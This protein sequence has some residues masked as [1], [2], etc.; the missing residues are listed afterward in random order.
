MRSYELLG[1]HELGTTSNQADKLV[2]A[3]R[4]G[5]DLIKKYFGH[6]SGLIY[7]QGEI[8][9]ID[10][11]LIDWYT[12]NHNFDANVTQYQ[13]KSKRLSGLQHANPNVEYHIISAEALCHIF[14]WLQTNQV[15]ISQHGTGQ[16]PIDKMDDL[17]SFLMLFND[18]VRSSIAKATHTATQIQDDLLPYRE[19]LTQS[20]P[21]YDIENAEPVELLVCQMYKG[22]R[23]LEFMQNTPKYQALHTKILADFGCSSNG[24]FIQRIVSI[25]API[26]KQLPGNTT[27]IIP[28]GPDFLADVDLFEKLALQPITGA[29]I[30]D[31]DYLELRSK[32]IYK[33]APGKYKIINEAFLC[34]VLYNGLCFYASTLCRVDATFLGGNTELPGELRLDFSEG[35]LLYDLAGAI[36]NSSSD[37]K[38]NGTQLNVMVPDRQ[39]D[40]Y[41][42]RN[43]KV[44]VFESKDVYMKGSEKLSYDFNV[45]EANLKKKGR[46]EKASLQLATNVI[47]VLKGELPLTAGTN[48]FKATIYPVLTVHNPLYS[49]RALN[50]W[51]N[52]WFDE[53]LNSLKQQPGNE[54]LNYNSVRPLTVIEVDT[55]ILYEDSFT[56]PAFNFLD[57]IDAYHAKVGM[58][59]IPANPQMRKQHAS[60]QISFADFIRDTAL[61]HRIIPG[62]QRIIAQLL[63]IGLS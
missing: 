26:L 39:P 29:A 48:V 59:G 15:N 14:I 41:A 20:F 9:E 55:M 12:I 58:R 2:L 44:V 11:L 61:Q 53:S 46:I 23:L 36:F 18:D 49:C 45:I 32:P 33:T 52:F 7:K 28:H 25:M 16:A 3:N 50:F 51:A 1:S 54:N 40:Y 57:Q 34:N 62:V 63:A 22:A 35:V 10:Q 31:Q 8:P 13:N 4:I 21:C 5:S 37:L 24:D 19:I 30:Y 42:C 38:F 43:N 60:N 6:Y 56:E 17:F 27:I 47:R